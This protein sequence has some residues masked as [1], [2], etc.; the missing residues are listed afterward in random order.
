MV[1]ARAR[2]R[3]AAGTPLTCEVGGAL[4]RRSAGESILGGCVGRRL[5]RGRRRRRRGAHVALPEGLNTSIVWIGIVVVRILIGRGSSTTR[6]G[7]LVPQLSVSC[8]NPARQRGQRAV[9]S[10]SKSSLQMLLFILVSFCDI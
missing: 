7:L 9:F 4:G 3:V 8:L 1:I 6:L 2:H 10:F 5:R